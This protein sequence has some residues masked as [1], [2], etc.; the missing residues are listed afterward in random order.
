MHYAGKKGFT[1]VAQKGRQ[2]EALNVGQLASMIDRLIAEKRAQVEGQKVSVDLTELG[3]RKLLGSGSISRAIRVKIE[4]CSG[5]ALEKLKKAGG[6]AIL[7]S[8][9]ASPV[10]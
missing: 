10:K 1:S 4:E 2:G 6:E 9:A 8:T 7:P 5:S 3:F